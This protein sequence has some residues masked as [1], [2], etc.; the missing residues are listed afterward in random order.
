MDAQTAN[1]KIVALVAQTNTLHN[2][3]IGELFAKRK[4]AGHVKQ[5]VEYLEDMTVAEILTRAVT[6]VTTDKDKKFYELVTLI[7]EI[8][9]GESTL[10]PVSSLW[11]FYDAVLSAKE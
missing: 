9:L 1:E 11:P 2:A 7:A 8:D 5:T 10:N 4:L 6:H 3:K